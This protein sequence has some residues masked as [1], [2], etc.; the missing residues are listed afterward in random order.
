[1]ATLK[2][3]QELSR[4][5]EKHHAIV[6]ACMV[7]FVTKDIFSVINPDLANELLEMSEAELQSLP[8]LFLGR[9]QGGFEDE[10]DKKRFPEVSEFARELSE[11]TLEALG[12]AVSRNDFLKNHLG[13]VDDGQDIMR[14]FDRF[15]SD[16]KMHEVVYMSQVVLEMASTHNINTL[17]DLGSGKAYLS[18][19]VT[20]QSKEPDLRVLA[21]DSS[22]TNSNSAS[23]RSHKLE[24]FWDGL[25]RRAEYRKDQKTPPPR[26]KHWKSKRGRVECPPPEAE[27]SEEKQPIS[28]RLKFVTQF[29]D[30]QTDF[31]SLLRS[32][33]GGGG[34]DEEEVARMG[35]IGLHTCGNLAPDSLRIFLS[36][37]DI[38]F[39]CNVGCCYH[40][41]HEEFYVNPYMAASEVA[42]RQAN[43]RFPLSNYLRQKKFQLGKNALMVA[44]QP[45]DRLLA[46]LPLPSESL[47]WRAILQV[48]LKNHKPD[49]KF[50]DQHVGRTAKKCENFVSYVHKSFEKLNLELQISDE[51]IDHVY[52]TFA[53]SH[54]QKLMGYYQLK[55]MLGPLIE[56]L[57]LLDRLQW[58][59]EKQVLIQV[60]KFVLTQ[61]T[62]RVYA[63]N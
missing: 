42:H 6:N 60:A 47:L 37:P 52:R 3:L 5:V 26:G 56:G 9:G 39:V 59:A 2:A 27:P 33:F 8:Q 55:S 40:H 24:K 44:A 4:V 20:A 31:Q 63:S 14:F 46:N 58:L 49:L 1:M 13:C 18:Q 19:V 50:E 29:V 57:I 43:P 61:I 21:V 38:R 45:M 11:H 36:S 16:K 53:K 41:L 48:I 34:E 54:R 10:E 12:V 51:E 15:M 23:K 25:I 62:K 35:L 28:E 30:T 17:L 7:D 22:Q 32:S